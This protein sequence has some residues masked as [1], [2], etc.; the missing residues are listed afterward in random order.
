MAKLLDSVAPDWDRARPTEGAYAMLMWFGNGA[1]AVAYGA[2]SAG[3]IIEDF[4]AAGYYGTTGAIVG[5]EL[6]GEPFE[7]EGRELTMHAPPW[8]WDAQM[9]VLPHVVGP[10]RE[11]AE[12]HVFEDVMQLVD[13]VRDGLPTAA[14]PEHARHVIEIIESGYRAAE[15]GQ[16]QTLRTTFD[17]V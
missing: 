14:T 8:D 6:N 7:F 4:A 16:T 17:A 12:S 1:F 11:I 2:A 9:H 15:S 13:L 5:L 3:T 10:H